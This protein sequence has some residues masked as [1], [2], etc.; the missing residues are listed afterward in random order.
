V[1]SSAAVIGGGGPLD[2]ARAFAQWHAAHRLVE[3][4]ARTTLQDVATLGL[5]DRLA[6]F[7]AGA[8][9]PGPEEINRA[10]WGACHGG[11]QPCAR[12]LLDRG[13]D[14]DWIPDWEN[15]TPLDAA[16]RSGATD[17]VAWLRAQGAVTADELG[18]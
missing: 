3:R 2:D 9:R 6:G 17:L 7:F 5:T 13:A 8:N 10:F 12:F 11:Q 4:G 14:R 1:R 18:R 16:T 15:R